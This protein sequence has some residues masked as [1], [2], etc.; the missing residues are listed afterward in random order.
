MGEDDTQQ[1]VQIYRDLVLRYEKLDEDID[2][3]I[4]RHGSVE[5]M[6]SEYLAHYRKLAREREDMQNEMRMLE[7]Q[8]KLDEE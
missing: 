4:A 5:Q 3:Y 6:D 1:R 7:K 8:L 2:A